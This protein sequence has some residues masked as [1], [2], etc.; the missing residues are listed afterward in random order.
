MPSLDRAPVLFTFVIYCAEVLPC[1]RFFF[2]CLAFPFR[3]S[4]SSAWFLI[5]SESRAQFKPIL[6]AKCTQP[7]ALS[8][9]QYAVATQ[10][11]TLHQQRY[12]S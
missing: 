7:S 6:I 3:S 8:H 5:S 1:D 10:R 12:H 4:F 9:R 11:A 2:F